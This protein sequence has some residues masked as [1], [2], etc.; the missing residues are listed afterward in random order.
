MLGWCCK[1]PQIKLIN[2]IILRNVSCS[3]S[4]LVLGRKQ[5]RLPPCY[6]CSCVLKC[7][8]INSWRCWKPKLV[9]RCPLDSKRSWGTSFRLTVG[10]CPDV[11]LF[12]IN[13]ALITGLFI[14]IKYSPSSLDHTC[15]NE[16]WTTKVLNFYTPRSARF[17]N[18]YSSVMYIVSSYQNACNIWFY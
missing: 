11:P 7:L 14:L 18:Q 6:F 5:K 3:S 13:L 17:D 10:R 12:G 16:N 1:R 2:L 8:W 4:I 15:I 9:P